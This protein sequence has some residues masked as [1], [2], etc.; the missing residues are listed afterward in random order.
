MVLRALFV[1]VVID[2]RNAVMIAQ[3]AKWGNSLALRIPNAL[4]QTLAVK[5]GRSVELKI[6]D[7]RLVVSPINEKPFY[8][9]EELLAGLTP[10]NLHAEVNY[11]GPVG[12]EFF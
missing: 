3:V 4:A 1:V 2:C 11:G 10:E 5:E 9:L 12:N 8:K 7:G 6:E